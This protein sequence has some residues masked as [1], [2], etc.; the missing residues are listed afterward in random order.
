MLFN[1][2]ALYVLGPQIEK[3][4]GKK[5]FIYIYIFSLISSSL[6]SLTFM[7]PGALSVGASGAIFGLLGSLAV[8][9]YYYRVYLGNVLK[10]QILPILL[11]NLMIGL[12]VPGIDNGAHI[13][14][15]IGGILATLAVGVDDKTDKVDKIN[16]RIISLLLIGLL[17]FLIIKK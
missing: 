4:L 14:G 6:M 7:Q 12:T 11:L 3:F 17:S 13:G 8:F 15:L 1:M 9:G 2:Y 10:S 16:A 5:K